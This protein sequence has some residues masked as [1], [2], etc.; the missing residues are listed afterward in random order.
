MSHQR[1]LPV[2]KMV[3]LYGKASMFDSFYVSRPI[4]IEQSG[5]M[6]SHANISNISHTQKRIHQH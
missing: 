2:M 4:V 6:R 5:M 1:N 3:L